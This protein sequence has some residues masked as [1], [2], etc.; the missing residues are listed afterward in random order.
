MRK[1]ISL[2]LLLGFGAA[3]GWAANLPAGPQTPAAA[4]AP[5]PVTAASSQ[6]AAPPDALSEA[7]ALY[8]KRDFAHAI[9]EYQQ[10]L[11]EQPNSGDAYAGLIRSYLKQKDVKQASDTAAKAL[12]TADSPPV[13]VAL[14]EVYFRQGKFQEAQHEW[15]TVI[16]SGHEDA[17]AYL[18]LARLRRAMSMYKMAQGLIARAY[19]LDSADPEV[20]DFWRRT[21]PIAEQIKYLEE[22]LAGESGDDAKTLEGMRRYLNFLKTR[23]NEPPSMCHLAGKI[24]AT[25]TPLVPLNWDTQ[26]RRATSIGIDV[27]VNGKKT[28]L[29]LD[30]GASGFV[31]NR[32]LAETA[33]VTKL[34]EVVIGGAGDE[35]AQTGYQGLASSLKIGELEFQDCKVTVL[36]RESA[37]GL[38]GADVFA[39]FLVDLDFPNH[40]LRLSE[41]PKRP[42]E[43]TTT[44]ALQT[45]GEVD[46]GSPEEKSGPAAQSGPQDRYLAPEMKAYT[47]VFRFGHMLLI[48]T[49]VGNAPP[50]L[51]LLDSGASVNQITPGLASE[52][53][54][55]TGDSNIIVKGLS[56]EVKNVYRADDAVLQFAHLR[57]DNQNLIAFDLTNISNSAGTEISGILG[58][59]VFR[60]LD[61]KIDYRDGLV[62]FTYDPKHRH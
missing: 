39:S 59:G 48:P 27:L 8:R 24:T 47:P 14:G 17:R 60:L 37:T 10:I 2:G 21:L 36:H 20:R 57:Q 7:R 61:F 40:K 53:A 26:N 3:G 25:E 35:G 50:G 55:V 11:K 38:V 41:L 45:E 4:A 19:Q 54:R 56:G 52:V 30:T 33:G 13:R 43:T 28:T 9:Q 18:G 31:I 6:P 46:S 15:V 32:G 44:I 16:N 49:S 12:Q 51:F 62:D 22:H 42:E 34:R 1:L 58:F 29:Q 23:A 5:A